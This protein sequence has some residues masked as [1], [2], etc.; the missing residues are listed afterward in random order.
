MHQLFLGIGK[1]LITFFYEQMRAEHKNQL[2]ETLSRISLSEFKKGIKQ[3]CPPSGL[4]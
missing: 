1:D 4:H 3:H 2:K